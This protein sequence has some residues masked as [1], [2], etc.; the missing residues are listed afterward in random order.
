MLDKEN[1]TNGSDQLALVFATIP[2][3]AGLLFLFY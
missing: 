1:K 2:S 3:N